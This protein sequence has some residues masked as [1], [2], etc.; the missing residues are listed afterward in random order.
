[1]SL[2]SWWRWWRALSENPVY[3]R[4]KGGWGKPNPFYD[5]LSRFS[6]FVVIGAVLFGLCAGSTN[7]IF[8]TGRDEL[9]AFWCFLCLPGIVLNMLSMFGSLMAPALT[10]PAVSMEMD[11]GTWEILRVTP[12][13]T[14]SILLAKMFGA[15]ARLRIWPV[16]FALSLLQ[17]SLIACV[18]TL[19]GSGAPGLLGPLIGLAAAVRPWLEILFAG[20]AG[21]YVSTRARSATLALVA[22]YTAVVMMKLFN[23][24][25]LWIGVFGLL[26]QEETMLLAGSVGPV[27]V[28]AFIIAGLLFGLSQ[29]ANRLSYE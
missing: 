13:S 23:S 22:S 25:S 27:L 26:D 29:Q 21:M 9:Y 11:R 16:L 1:L 19:S 8:L 5:N 15:L 6:P 14:G 10:A 18:M 2:I 4:E 28:Y 20:T 7:P 24:S 17:G 12:Q 3:R